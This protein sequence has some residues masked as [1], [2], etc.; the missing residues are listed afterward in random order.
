VPADLSGL[1]EDRILRM[2]AVHLEARQAHPVGSVL[3]AKAVLDYDRLKG[4]LDRRLTAVIV[5][6]AR[7]RE[8]ELGPDGDTI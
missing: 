7:E 1:P 2:M 8:G 4:E 5:E 6:A 3:W